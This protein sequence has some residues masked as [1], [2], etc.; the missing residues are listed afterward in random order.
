MSR[1][2]SSHASPQVAPCS[3]LYAGIGGIGGTGGAGSAWILALDLRPC[4][5]V[6]ASLAFTRHMLV[7]STHAGLYQVY[8]ASNGASSPH[9]HDRSQ[10]DD[11]DRQR[12]QRKQREQ[13]KHR[14]GSRTDRLVQLVRLVELEPDHSPPVT[15]V[16]SPRSSERR[17]AAPPPAGLELHLPPPGR[18]APAPAPDLG[19]RALAL[20]CARGLGALA[21]GLDL[22]RRVH[23]GDRGLGAGPVGTTVIGAD[24]RLTEHRTRV[25][26]TSRRVLPGWNEWL[27]LTDQLV[28]DAW[29]AVRS[30]TA[31]AWCAC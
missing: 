9:H 13:G 10:E 7:R 2:H 8:R 5:R 11:V 18:R 19:P 23:V 3:M 31:A 28:F 22:S 26:Q 29:E 27:Y 4:G 6:H 16:P 24:G 20:G 12:Q 21:P 1:F 25:V 14:A 15:D 30:T 17:R